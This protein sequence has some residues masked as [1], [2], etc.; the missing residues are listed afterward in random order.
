[1]P[2]K[3]QILKFDLD[4]NLVAEFESVAKAMISIGKSSANGSHL[5]Q[6]ILR[7]EPYAGFFL[8]I[9]RI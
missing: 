6:K 8:E 5:R 9:Q 7:K 1:M 3:R 2:P 4:W